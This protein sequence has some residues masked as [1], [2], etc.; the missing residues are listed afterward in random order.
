MINTIKESFDFHK[1]GKF[2]RQSTKIEAEKKELAATN[3]SDGSI[4][5]PLI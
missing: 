2:V 1:A 4:I 3:I 5:R